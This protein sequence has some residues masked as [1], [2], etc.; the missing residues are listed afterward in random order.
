[1]KHPRMETLSYCPICNNKNLSI[2][3]K[4][5]DYFLSQQPFNIVEC[6]ECGFLFT[7]PRPVESDAAQYYESEEYLSHNQEQKSLLNLMYKVVKSFTIKNKAF[8]I[9]KNSKDKKILD[10]GCGTGDFLN[11]LQKRGYDVIG[12]EP[13]KMARESAQAQY[14][15]NIHSTISNDS[16]KENS[17]DIITMWHVLEHVYML[18]ESLMRI[19]KSLTNNGT[20]IVALPNPDSYDAKHY[21]RFWAAY[22]LPRHLYHFRKENVQIL[23]EKYGFELQKIK[24]MIFDAFYVGILSERYKQ[25]SMVYLKA[26]YRATL[27]NF[28]AFFGNRNYSSQIYIFKL[29]KG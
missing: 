23:F 14:G 22:D 10:I 6:N 5:C 16:I 19:K 8:L 29:K 4:S 9:A 21:K 26:F 18:N 20:L 7:N 28:K 25:N 13:N 24:P 15:L 27:S 17:V 2:K 3:L 1:M 12:V 11:V